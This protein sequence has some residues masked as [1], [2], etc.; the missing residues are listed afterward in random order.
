LCRAAATAVQATAAPSPSS[1]SDAPAHITASGVEGGGGGGGRGG[2]DVEAP[3]NEEPL[4]GVTAVQALGLGLDL[5]RVSGAGVYGCGGLNQAESLAAFGGVLL[6]RRPAAA[7]AA[8]NSVTSPPPARAPSAASPLQLK[9]G[10][11]AGGIMGVGSEGPMGKS[12]EL[13]RLMSEGEAPCAGHSVVLQLLGPLVSLTHGSSARCAAAR[14]ALVDVLLR[15]LRW[16]HSAAQRRRLMLQALALW[17]PHLRPLLLRLSRIASPS[18]ALYTAVPRLAAAVDAPLGLVVPVAP[19]ATETKVVCNLAFG[20]TNS[21][22]TMP[23]H[24]SRT[25]RVSTPIHSAHGPPHAA[26]IP[27]HLGQRTPPW[28]SGAAAAAGSGSAAGSA[29]GAI[30]AQ[31]ISPTRHFTSVSGLRTAVPAA[32][33]PGRGRRGSRLAAGLSS[34]LPMQ[35]PRGVGFQGGG[36]V[37]AGP[38]T[39]AAAA[40]AV[41]GCTPDA[42]TECAPHVNSVPLEALCEL[43]EGMMERLADCEVVRHLHATGWL[44][45]LCHGANCT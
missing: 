14:A 22:S 15:V 9:A 28:G 21:Q 26:G 16:G 20:R 4:H 13:L 34:P 10:P 40:A 36:D 7:A 32:P 41:I 42:D 27:A 25:G 33:N 12:W 17:G 23:Y 1:A 39:A 31:V 45:A 37:D 6:L 19:A 30:A 5:L 8:H 18:P 44:R 35:A 38:A 29:A 3:W 2:G 24:G 43:L 11:S